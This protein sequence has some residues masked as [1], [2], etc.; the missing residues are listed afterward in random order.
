MNHFLCAAQRWSGVAGFAGLMAS[1]PVPAQEVCGGVI[2]PFPYTDVAGIGAAFCPGIMEAY[3]TGVSK[4][5]S[6]TTFTP[7]QSVPRV[8]MTTFLQRSLDAGLARGSRRAALDQWW[9]TAYGP[10]TPV[11]GAPFTCSADGEFIWTSTFLGDSVVQVQASTGQGVAD[12]TGLIKSAGVRVADGMVYVAGAT[13]PGVLYVI[14]PTQL[15]SSMVNTFD[16]LGNQPIGVAF[17]GVSVWTANRGP[18]GSVSLIYP[19][20]GGPVINITTGFNSPYGIL[21]DGTN[22]WVT[23]T[24][25]GTLL[26]LGPY[27]GILQTIAVGALPG[28]PVFDG[29]NIWVPNFNDNSV[30]VVQARTGNVLATIAGDAENKLNGPNGASFDGQRILIANY[31]GKTVSLFN[32]VDLSFIANFPVLDSSGFTQT[33]TSACSDGINFWIPVQSNGTLLRF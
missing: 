32:A 20:P 14:D 19:H 22:I 1:A 4:G 17:D 29:A 21:F 2:Y 6:P 3:V 28:F 5:T 13:S 31:T 8:Q 25:T 27:G 10:M 30:T 12:W 23:D 15:P 24:G 11:G 9:P 18:P 7:N 26:Q 33:P 16:N